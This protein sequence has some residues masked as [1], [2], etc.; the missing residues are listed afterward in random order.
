MFGFFK[1]W[2]LGSSYDL[3]NVSADTSVHSCLWLL[4]SGKDRQTLTAWYG[5]DT[6]EIPIFPYS[7][8][9]VKRGDDNHEI[10][11]LKL[12]L[13]L[14]LRLMLVLFFINHFPFLS[15][16]FELVSFKIF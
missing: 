10:I 1:A 16:L 6:L 4:L 14:N 5:L 3:L 9:K 8:T 7:K 2:T 11:S 13:R 15:L 12:Y